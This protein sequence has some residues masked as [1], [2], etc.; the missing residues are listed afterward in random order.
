MVVTKVFIRQ[1]KRII[2]LIAKKI[3]CN[4]IVTLLDTD[5]YFCRICS[6]IDVK[7][8][9]CNFHDTNVNKHFVLKASENSPFKQIIPPQTNVIG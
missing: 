3:E 4:T 7:G 5:I 6:N 8:G 1:G 9:M 2:H